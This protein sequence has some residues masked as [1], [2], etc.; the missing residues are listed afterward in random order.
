M[1]ISKDAGIPALL[2]SLVSFTVLLGITW[3]LVKPTISTAV[4]AELTD[5]ISKA[6]DNKIAPLKGGFDVLLTQQ[7]FQTQREIAQ[8]ERLGSTNLTVEQT[9]RLVELRAQLEAQQRALQELRR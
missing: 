2:A 4:A 1:K 8:L 3:G 9:N 7:I 6:V 5:E